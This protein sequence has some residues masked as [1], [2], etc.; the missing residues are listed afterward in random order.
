MKYLLI[1]LLL[2]GCSN[3]ND[4]TTQLLNDKKATEDSIKDASNYNSYYLQKAKEEIH[5]SNDTLKWKPLIDSST[6]YFFKGHTLKEKLK[7]IEFSLDS[8]SKMK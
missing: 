8:L 5:G 6:F 2:F 1:S 3:R 4:L 7:T